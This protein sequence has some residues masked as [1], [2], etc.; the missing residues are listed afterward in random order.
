MLSKLSNIS[1]E[2]SDTFTPIQI[3]ATFEALKD[4]A[5]AQNEAN[6]KAIKGEK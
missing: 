6:E 2:T 3:E 4:I 5:E 1:I